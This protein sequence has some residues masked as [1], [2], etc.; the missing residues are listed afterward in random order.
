MG[1]RESLQPSPNPSPVGEMKL[2]H[3][4]QIMEI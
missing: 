1:E 4:V 2:I 3:I